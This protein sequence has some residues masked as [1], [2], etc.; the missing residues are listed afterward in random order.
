MAVTWRRAIPT[1]KLIFTERTTRMKQRL[2]TTG[3]LW[4]A[5]FGALWGGLAWAKSGAQT[6]PPA[7]YP[8]YGSGEFFFP[9]YLSDNDRM[10]YGKSSSHDTTALKA[11]WYV[12]WGASKNPDHFAGAHYARTIYFNVS[13][14]WCKAATKSSQVTANYTGTRLINNVKANPGAL[15][16]VGNEPD[17]F[18]NG[19]PIHPKLYAELYHHFYTTIKAAD[20]TA[21][22]A[23]AAIVQ[24]SPL[25]MEYLDHVLNRYQ[26]LYGQPLPS[27]LWT[28]HLYRFNEGVC[29]SWGAAIPP[30]S[31]A[32]QGWNINFTP[33][34]LLNLTAMEGDL[35]AFRQ[36]MYNRGYGDQPLIISE[37][38]VLPPPNYSGFSNAVAAQFLTDSFAMFLTAADPTTGLAADGGRL[39]QM[40]SWFSTDHNPPPGYF[41]YG[42]DLFNANGSLTVIGN[43][44]VA[45]TT[46]HYTPYVDLEPVPPLEV[47]ES[48][49]GLR[50]AAYLQNR[51]NTG[52]GNSPVQLSLVEAETGLLAVADTIDLGQIQRRYAAPPAL[53]SYTW[54][55]TFTQPPTRTVPYT[56][57][58]TVPASGTASAGNGLSVR[59]NWWPLQDLAVTEL[60]L[61]GGAVFR[62]REPVTR[63]A[64]AT[65]MNLGLGVTPKTALRFTLRRPGGQVVALSPPLPVKAL[66]P[67]AGASFTASVPI[68]GAG[69]FELSAVLSATRGTVDLTRN[70][71]KTL[72]ILAATGTVYLPLL[73]KETP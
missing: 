6:P 68:T 40:W 31:S 28:I 18:Y 65:V 56:L 48:D 46:G 34:D 15:W 43:A 63:V 58:I 12:D 41:K 26:T 36:W 44:F 33:A 54:Q 32:S 51:G 72:N 38:G 25:R 16:L 50:V 39:V 27:D 3:I 14:G 73:L 69:M 7:P 2:L 67:M 35:R 11:G 59:V 57:S 24:P 37:Y 70:N 22:V 19:S 21:K 20:P 23:V 29:G 66:E 49:T 4:G 53:I 55:V 10:G 60:A 61:S 9:P 13:T 1:P 47:V 42:G 17:S 45:Q 62:Y 30:A 71:R 52:A 5:L 64:T 8:F